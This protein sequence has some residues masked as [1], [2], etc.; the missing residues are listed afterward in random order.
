MVRHMNA[1]QIVEQLKRLKV[2]HERIAEAIGRD[3]TAATKMLAGTRSIKAAELP[4]LFALV[5]EYG[6]EHTGT[7][8]DQ[9]E[10]PP[11]QDYVEVEVLPTHA[12]MGGGGTGD[13]DRSTTLLPRMLVETDLR[14]TAADILVIDVRG[15]SMDPVFQEGDRLAVNR[16]LTNLAQPGP[17][18]LWDGD[19]Y[20][21]KNIQRDSK[22]K[23]I[24]VF[25]ENPKYKEQVYAEDDDT[26]IIMGRPVWFARRL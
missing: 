6:G 24:R 16:R 15:D 9:P 5:S 10:R 13:A 22:T 1:D 8:P 2:P 21:V 23:T 4:A 14:A 19:G 17:F 18:A 11:L 12:G 26:L 3:R 7:T 25:S 20:V